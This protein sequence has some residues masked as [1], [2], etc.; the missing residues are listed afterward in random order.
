MPSASVMQVYV[1]RVA[2][3]SRGGGSVVAE[4]RYDI[5]DLEW[6]PGGALQV[7][8]PQSAKVQQRSETHFYFGETIPIVYRMK[9]A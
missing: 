2:G 1:E 6:L 9:T 4:C 5:V 7:T 8:Y 3:N